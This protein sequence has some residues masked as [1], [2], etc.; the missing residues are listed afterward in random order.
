MRGGNVFDPGFFF[1]TATRARFFIHVLQ[2]RTI[3]FT[4]I[5][6]FFRARVCVCVCVCVV[7]EGERGDKRGSCIY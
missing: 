6:A 5:L 3:A 1:L 7:G 2:P 4:L